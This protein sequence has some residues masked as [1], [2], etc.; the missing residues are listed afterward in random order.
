MNHYETLIQK[1]LEREKEETKKGAQ[2]GSV[3]LSRLEKRLERQF[4]PKFQELSFRFALRL[5]SVSSREEFDLF[6]R[7]YIQA[8]RQDIKTRGGTIVSYGEAQKPVNIFLKE[9]VEKSKLMDAALAERLSP[10][11]HVTL[12]GIIIM[13]MQSFFREDYNAFIAPVSKHCGL[14]DTFDIT[15][16]R[17][18]DISES[19]QNQLMFINHEVY[20]A[21]QSWFRNISPGR[22]VLLDTVWSIARKT[23]LN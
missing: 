11:L 6:H 17:N 15:Q 7:S 12:D 14:I 10:L 21:W 18:K 8:F 5:K 23:L 22:P 19:L 1:C 3:I 9:Y 20:T 2:I 16:Y 13:Y 4:F